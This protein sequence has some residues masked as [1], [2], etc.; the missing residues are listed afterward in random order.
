M[1]ALSDTRR[2]IEVKGGEEGEEEGGNGYF[3]PPLYTHTHTQLIK[4]FCVLFWWGY[5]YLFYGEKEE[6]EENPHSPS[7]AL[8]TGPHL[9]ASSSSSSSCTGI[10]KH[11][12]ST[13]DANVVVFPCLVL[14]PLSTAKPLACNFIF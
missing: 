6:E 2:D 5:F 10:K 7:G 4:F 3:L 9:L 14:P 12:R 1:G 13:G 11:Q 8:C